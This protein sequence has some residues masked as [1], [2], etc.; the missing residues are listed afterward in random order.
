MTHTHLRSWGRYPDLPQTPRTVFW[1]TDTPHL[2]Q[3][4]ATQVGSTLAVGGAL[5]Y[6]D[7]CLAASNQVLHLPA[8]NRFMRADWAHGVLTA[9]AGVTLEQILA[10]AIPRGWF[11]PVTPGTK[12]ITLGG[13]I[14]ND[15]H[16]KNHHRQG[17]FG[18]HV[19]RI[20]LLRSDQGRQECTPTENSEMFAATVGGLGLTGIIEWAEIQLTPIASSR[21]DGLTQR[22]NDLDEFFALS[23]ELD[24]QH[25]FCVSWIDCAST[26]ANLGR[27]IY[28]AGNFANQ[29][30][31]EVARPRTLTVPFTPPLSLVNRVSLRVFNELYWRR[32]P[33]S[34]QQALT[35]YDPFFY[36]LDAILL[37]NRIYGPRGFQQYQA[38]IPESEARHGIQALL[39]A[40]GRSGTGSFLAVLKRCS[41]IPSP[42]WLS[43]PAAGTTLALDFPHHDGLASGLF[44]RLDAIVRKTGGR[45]YPAKDAHMS[46]E[47]FRRSYPAWEKLEAMRDPALLSQFWQRVTSDLGTSPR[48]SPVMAPVGKATGETRGASSKQI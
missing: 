39:A 25:E 28:T 15:V 12:Y 11:L 2:L 13:A 40:I 41:D 48:P 44:A 16:G 31:L 20:G 43:F 7:S 22:F 38:L 9:E 36:P 47:D 27:G 3:D 23:D 19:Q 8:L 14:A 18:R 34:R 37:W 24:A 17:C 35:G 21:I 10:L 6:G 33:A 45:L 30:P 46:G 32:A 1:R 29:G 4:I 26:G 5:S 42:G